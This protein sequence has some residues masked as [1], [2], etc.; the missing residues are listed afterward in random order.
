[1]RNTKSIA[2]IA[3]VL[4]FAQNYGFTQ[5]TAANNYRFHE[6]FFY[7]FTKY[8]QWPPSNTGRDFI[9]A[10]LGDSDLTPLLE[11]MSEIKKA[12]TD[13]IVVKKINEGQLNQRANILFVPNHSAESFSKVIAA[14]EGKPVLLITETEGLA[15]KGSMI[16]FKDVNGKLRFEINIGSIQKAGLKVSQELVR[17]GEEIE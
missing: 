4:F 14:L 15:G 3:L 8:V 11:E 10:V 16:N 1:M 6:V 5:N 13:N 9:I 12:G 2:I 17:F 7:S